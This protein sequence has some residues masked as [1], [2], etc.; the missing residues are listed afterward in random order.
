M[1]SGETAV[2]VSGEETK[3]ATWHHHP[4]LPLGNVPVFVWPLRLIEAFKY[5][6][7]REYILVIGPFIATGTLSW[8]F[9]QPAIET[10][11]TFELGW[12][13]WL[14]VRNFLLIF[15]VAG[16]LHLYFYVFKVQGTDRKYDA[17]TPTLKD[18]PRFFMNNQVW[19]NMLYTLGS[20]VTVW[21]AYEVFYFWAVANNLVPYYLDVRTHPISFVAM[22]LL[23]PFW[24]SFH[25]HFVHR[26]LHWRPL[27]KFAHGVHHR[28]VSLGPWSGFSMHP[29]DAFVISQ[30]GVDTYRAAHPSNPLFVPHAMASDGRQRLAFRLRIS[31]HSWRTRDG[32]DLVPSPTASQAP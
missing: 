26:L 29:L 6:F 5:I 4:E 18:T 9:L 25:F 16:G 28:N 27:F 10:C 21:T 1:A 7:S 3:N 19:D 23:I 17:Q 14:F 32:H 2:P 20:G 22:F 8:Y 11:A 30:H 24:S 13:T 15:I 31:H 12:I